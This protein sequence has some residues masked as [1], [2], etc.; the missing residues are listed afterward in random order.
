MTET[1]ENKVVK[2]VRKANHKRTL[3]ELRQA[4][5]EKL[6]NY[7]DRV[8]SNEV[9]HIWTSEFRVKKS[10]LN[11]KKELDYTGKIQEFVDW[12]SLETGIYSSMNIET[13]EEE[14]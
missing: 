12:I 7:E 4:T 13:E 3:D 6:K 11:Q 2:K 9:K 10:E 14:E 1:K 5:E 8:K